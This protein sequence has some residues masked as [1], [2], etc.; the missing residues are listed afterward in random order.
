MASCAHL[1]EDLIQQS[2]TL[3]DLI[4]FIS[5]G[6]L[7]CSDLDRAILRRQIQQA[8]A[9]SDLMHSVSKVKSLSLCTTPIWII[10]ES[11]GVSGLE[12]RLGCP[13]WTD[14][15]LADKMRIDI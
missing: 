9:L 3:S 6:H 1:C 12:R 2:E 14:P 11:C 8:E 13:A 7:F 15:D 5:F 4:N 10:L